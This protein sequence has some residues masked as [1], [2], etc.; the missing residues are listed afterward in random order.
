MLTYLSQF[1]RAK[2]QCYRNDA[3]WNIWKERFSKKHPTL[4]VM[5]DDMLK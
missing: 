5:L 3:A 1:V 2:D 4:K